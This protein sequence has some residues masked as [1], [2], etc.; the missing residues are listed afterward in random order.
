MTI[1]LLGGSFN[2]AHSGHV[3]ISLAALQRLGLDQVW[4]LVSP[5]NPLKPAAGMA[6]Y[7][8]RVAHARSLASDKR[9]WVSTLEQELGTRYTADTLAALAKR[10][11]GVRFVWLMGA[12]NLASI[13]RWQRWRTIFRTL[14]IA[15]LARPD[16]AHAALAAP[17]ARCFHAARVVESAARTLPRTA[18]PAWVFLHT[19]LDPT[20]ATALRNRG[21]GLGS[22]E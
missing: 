9:I 20:S 17:A 12:D 19:R 5:Q 15:V 2:P 10:C 6:A 4:W 14:P 13:H 11:P 8:A 16:Y 3:G 7:A 18:P 22:T 21:Q 1:G